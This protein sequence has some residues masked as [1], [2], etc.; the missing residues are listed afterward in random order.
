[1]ALAMLLLYR[2]ATSNHLIAV[3]VEGATRCSHAELTRDVKLPEVPYS[4]PKGRRA[5]LILPLS[6]SNRSYATQRPQTFRIAVKDA[7]YFYRLIGLSTTTCRISCIVFWPTDQV[8][9][10]E[11]ASECRCRTR[12]RTEYPCVGGEHGGGLGVYCTT[13]DCGRASPLTF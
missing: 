12:H 10:H 3:F 11:E 2:R 8:L 4:R 7:R 1:M 13:L 9:I 5:I 6:I